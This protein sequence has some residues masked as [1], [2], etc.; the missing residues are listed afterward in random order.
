MADSSSIETRSK[1]K[2]GSSNSKKKT[3]EVVKPTSPPADTGQDEAKTDT[4]ARSSGS[5]DPN[6]SICLGKLENK[7][8]T[9]SCFH[10]FCFVCLLEWSKVKNECPLCK[11]SFKSIIHNVRSYEDYDQYHLIISRPR[12]PEHPYSRNFRYRTT[13]TEDR[14]FNLRNRVIGNP[15]TDP[16][17]VLQLQAIGAPTNYPV[18]AYEMARQ[19]WNRRRQASTSDFRRR[20]YTNGMRL[21]GIRG[22]NNRVRECSPAF[23]T[24][25]P[26]LTHRL[27]PWLNRELNALLHDEELH[28]QFLLELIMGLVKRFDIGSEDFYQ[29]VSPFIGRHTRQFMREFESFAKCPYCMVVYDKKAM[30]EHV[31]ESVSSDSSTINSVSDDDSDVQFISSEAAPANERT[32]EYINL[33]DI[34]SEIQVTSTVDSPRNQN[35]LQNAGWMSPTPGPSWGFEPIMPPSRQKSFIPSLK[36]SVGASDTEVDSSADSLSSA[37]SDVQ[38]VAYDKPWEERSPINLSSETEIERPVKEKKLK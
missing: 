11:Q 8:F 3:E 32:S 22:A 6:C 18:Q 31:A 4:H 37:G 25:N 9:D 24:R 20:I 35:F 2:K 28:V 36:R 14:V 7:S 17:T 30:Y 21:T 29:H 12:S 27:V 1:K 23:F 15:V 33:P 10:M 19:N 13:L 38:V 26:A 34:S 16:E 5:P